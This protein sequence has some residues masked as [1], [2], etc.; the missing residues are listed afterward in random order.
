MLHG[1]VS[2]QFEIMYIFFPGGGIVDD[3]GVI[4]VEIVLTK[5][6]EHQLF[7]LCVSNDCE[8]SLSLP[9]VLP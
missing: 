2:L 1:H 5:E 8:S 9:Y 3:G 6:E 4:V 7:F